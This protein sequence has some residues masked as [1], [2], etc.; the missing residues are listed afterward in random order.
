MS[1]LFPNAGMPLALVLDDS[2]AMRAVLRRALSRLGFAV[3][4]ASDLGA[5]LDLAAHAGPLDLALVDWNLPGRRGLEFVRA[6]RA[7][8]DGSRLRVIMIT[9]ELD[10]GQV[11]EAIRVGVDEYLIQP[12]TSEMLESKLAVLGLAGRPE[13]GRKP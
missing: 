10:S 5:A 4:E 13:H 9:T 6:V 7:G 3:L 1:A 12:F 8:R 11:L 2:S